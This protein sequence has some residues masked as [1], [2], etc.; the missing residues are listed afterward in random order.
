M[1]LF[2]KVS[3]IWGLFIF[4]ER[5]KSKV[6][7]LTAMM[8]LL[9]GVWGMSYFSS[10]DRINTDEKFNVVISFN[11]SSTEPSSNEYESKKELTAFQISTETT[12]DTCDD[13]IAAEIVDTRSTVYCFFTKLSKRKFGLCC[14][15][16]NGLWGGSIMV[17]MHYSE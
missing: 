15:I 3:F 12:F 6:V 7:A 4:E 17:P 9:I 1:L 8:L 16:F 11:E 10:P 13:I 14:A 2:E 5:V